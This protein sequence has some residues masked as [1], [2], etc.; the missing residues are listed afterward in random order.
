VA[1]A[2][3]AGAFAGDRRLEANLEAENS[4]A[5]RWTARAAEHFGNP[6]IVAPALVAVDL[7]GRFTRHPGLAAAAERIG[8][9]IAVAGVVALALKEVVG[10]ARPIERPGDPDDTRAF[11]GRESFPSGHTT[12]AFA[13]ASALDAEARSRWA[14]WVAYPVAAAVGWSRVRDREHWPSDV[15]AGAALGGWLAR[16]A[17]AR[18]R[19]VW[20]HPLRL[21]IVPDGREARLGALVRF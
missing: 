12:V 3:L 8:L 13:F 16:H 20:R 4:P 18:L 10:R 9:S 14:P 1:G 15:V 5:A 6:A 11:S 2:A 19:R 17:D 7:A 21:G